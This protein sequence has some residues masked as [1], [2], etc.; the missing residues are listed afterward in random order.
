MHVPDRVTNHLSVPAIE[1]YP[2]T[3][4]SVL[5][6]GQSEVGLCRYTVVPDAVLNTSYVFSF[7][8][9]DKP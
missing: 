1:G 8:T 9:P 3:G 4:T 6:L 5:K 7:N 2:D